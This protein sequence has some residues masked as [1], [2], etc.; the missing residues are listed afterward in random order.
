MDLIEIMEGETVTDQVNDGI[1]L[2][3]RKKGL[4]FGTDALLLAACMP[5]QKKPLRAAELGSGTGIISLLCLQRNKADRIYA[6]EIQKEYAELTRF[7]AKQNGFDNKLTVICKNVK[8][9]VFAD[10]GGELDAV[11]SNPP[12]M[13]CGAGLH[14]TEGEKDIARRE[15]C[16]TVSDFANAAARLLKWGGSFY[17]VYRPERLTALIC[18]LKNAK[19]EP[20]KLTFVYEHPEAEPCL[21]LCT[22]KKGSGEGLKVTRP[23]YLRKDKSSAE[24]SP[25]VEAVYNGKVLEL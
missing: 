12:Y 17:C 3:Q 5:E 19:L 10:C 25:E 23:L 18:A 13:A 24:Y 22:A 6:Y 14:C 8:D 20:K 16:G 9:A 7:N 11:F 15:I 2:T 21:V 4:K 1:V